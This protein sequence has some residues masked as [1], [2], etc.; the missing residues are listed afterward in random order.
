MALNF[1]DE[2]PVPVIQPPR[3]ILVS[4]RRQYGQDVVHPES[5]EAEIFCEIAGT[6]TLTKP[7]IDRVKQLG[8]KV[9]VM[10]TLP[11]EL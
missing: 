10:Q 8:Y 6:K 3:E 9:T 4:I 2:V 11:I 5:R 7:T 1:R